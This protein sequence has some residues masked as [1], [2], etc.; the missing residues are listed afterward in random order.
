[1]AGLCIADDELCT[2]LRFY[3][4]D[5]VLWEPDSIYTCVYVCVRILY[6]HVCMCVSGVVLVVSKV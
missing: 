5:V 6:I 4:G 2:V 1:M 3:W